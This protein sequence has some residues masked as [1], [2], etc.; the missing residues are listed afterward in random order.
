ML[1]LCRTAFG[2]PP[3]LTKTETNADILKGGLQPPTIRN[4]SQDAM[5]HVLKSAHWPPHSQRKKSYRYRYRYIHLRAASG[6][7]P[8]TSKGK[9]AEGRPSA[10]HHAQTKERCRYR[11][12]IVK[13]SLRPPTMHNK[14][15]AT[16]T[17]VPKS[18][19]RSPAMRNKR[20]ERAASG[21]P[22]AK[23]KGGYRYRHRYRYRYTEGRP[24]ATHH[25][26]QWVRY[27]YRSSERRPSVEN[28][29]C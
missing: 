1:I 14:R 27:R 3:C 13:D 7:P 12:D 5:C 6:R 24:S 23:Q 28:I 25:A 20:K 8:H 15:K 4:E 21:R 9:N 2:P 11:Y 26:Q 16:D 18:S 22:H 29:D 17:D 19:L 10:A